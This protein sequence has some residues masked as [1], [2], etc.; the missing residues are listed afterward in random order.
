MRRIAARAGV[1]AARAGG[2]AARAGVLAA[3]A[4]NGDNQGH[5]HCQKSTCGSFLPHVRESLPHVRPMLKNMDRFVLRVEPSNV[6][7]IC[8]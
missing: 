8:L 1:M 4:G 5:G 6:I 3:R 7:G 2:A